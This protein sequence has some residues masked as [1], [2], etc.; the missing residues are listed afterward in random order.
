MNFELLALSRIG[1]RLGRLP[2]SSP[3]QF[4]NYIGFK[5]A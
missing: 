5:K 3:G 1:A 2:V 4:D